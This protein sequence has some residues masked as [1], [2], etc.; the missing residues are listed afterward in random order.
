MLDSGNNASHKLEKYH[1][2]PKQN[3]AETNEKRCTDPLGLVRLV[4]LVVQ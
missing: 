2:I 4:R 3:L 1:Q